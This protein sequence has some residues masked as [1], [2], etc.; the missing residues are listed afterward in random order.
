MQVYETPKRG[1]GFT[2]V[3]QPVRRFRQQREAPVNPGDA[4]KTPH[5]QSLLFQQI[6]VN[7]MVTV[8]DEETGVLGCLAAL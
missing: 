1:P 5:K 3:P 4:K 8:A 2:D 6:D 7:I